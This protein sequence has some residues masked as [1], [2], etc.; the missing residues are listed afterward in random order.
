MAHQAQRNYLNQ[1]R[2]EL[3]DYFANKKV[4]E[5]GSLN[6]NGTARDFFTNCEYIG[7]DVAEG[8]CV[9]KV[10]QGQ[11][12]DGPDDNFDVTISCECFEHNPEW[13]ATFRN[14]IRLTKPGG[15][16]IMTCATTGRREHGTS[17]SDVYSSPLTVKIG[18][19]YYK[20]LEAR[21]FQEHFDFD[22]LFSQYMF[23]KND[24]AHDLYFWGIK[25]VI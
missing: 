19:E 25:N 17:R 11:D 20:N 10:V 24:G 8:P 21:D 3:P 23:L 9:D 1:V 15:L 7:L 13:V 5:I 2:N 6:I 4:L 14:M 22:K 18:W 16:V 12:Y